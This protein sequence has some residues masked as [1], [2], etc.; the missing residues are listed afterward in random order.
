MRS[1]QIGYICREHVQLGIGYI[2]FQPSTLAHFRGDRAPLQYPKS[3]HTQHTRGFETELPKGH[4]IHPYHSQSAAY[5]TNSLF[6]SVTDDVIAMIELR[7][8]EPFLVQL[9]RIVF[10]DR[11]RFRRSL[12]LRNHLIKCSTH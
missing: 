5:A 8:I 11:T 10:R 4:S 3:Y 12:F 9:R 1:I 6:R 2:S 7:L